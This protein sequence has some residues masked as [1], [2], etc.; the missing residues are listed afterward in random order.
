MSDQRN[1]NPQAL[2]SGRRIKLYMPRLQQ[3]PVP[4]VS[5]ESKVYMYEIHAL[6]QIP[7]L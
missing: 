5:T 4:R 3:S 2:N 1:E 6:K 7:A